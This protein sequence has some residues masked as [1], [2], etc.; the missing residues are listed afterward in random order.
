MRFTVQGKVLSKV[1]CH[2][3][4][5]I[6]AERRG[7]T[8]DQIPL[9]YGSIR[10]AVNLIKLKDTVYLIDKTS[11]DYNIKQER[12]ILEISYKFNTNGNIIDEHNVIDDLSIKEDIELIMDDA[13]VAKNHYLKFINVGSQTT[14]KSYF[15]KSWANKIYFLNS[16]ADLPFDEIIAPREVIK[17]LNLNKELIIV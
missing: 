1:E 4:R 8:L 10:V 15:L 13:F 6:Q 17:T 16:I 11:N 7:I 12:L 5:Q 3:E 9:K 14:I 2:K